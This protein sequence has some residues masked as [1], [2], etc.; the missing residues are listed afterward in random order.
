[1]FGFAV[2]AAKEGKNGSIEPPDEFSWSEYERTNAEWQKELND[3]EKLQEWISQLA[4]IN[5]IG[6]DWERV[7]EIVQVF[8]EKEPIPKIK[9]TADAEKKLDKLEKSIGGGHTTYIPIHLGEDVQAL[10]QKIEERN[11]KLRDNYSLNISE[12]TLEVQDKAGNRFLATVGVGV[13]A[14]VIRAIG[15]K[16]YVEAKAEAI[17]KQQAMTA[18]LQSKE[19]GNEELLDLQKLEQTVNGMPG[20]RNARGEGASAATTVPDT[21]S[22][23]GVPNAADRVLAGVGR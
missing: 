12:T 19:P 9:V 20:A 22:A 4:Q 23:A 18:L 17:A 2:N 11:Q 16:E 8:G 1:M 14:N 15:K 5:T 13:T 10:R 3:P 21:I 7:A 6:N